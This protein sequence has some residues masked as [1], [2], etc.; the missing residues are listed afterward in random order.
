M[1]VRKGFGTVVADSGT[2]VIEMDRGQHE[3]ESTDAV[4]RTHRSTS[5]ESVGNGTRVFD[6]R[7]A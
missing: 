3:E 1:L 6:G 7:R 2:D 5:M 4:E